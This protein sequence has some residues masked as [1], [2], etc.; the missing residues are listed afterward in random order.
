MSERVD[1]QHGKS[2]RSLLYGLGL[3][4]LFNAFMVGLAIFPVRARSPEAAALLVP[5]EDCADP[6]WQRIQPGITRIGSAIYL[7]RQSGLNFK[8]SSLGPLGTIPIQTSRG[9]LD[10]HLNSGFGGFK[11]DNTIASIC[12][13]DEERPQ[14]SLWL[15][16]VLAALGAPDEVRLRPPNGNTV[17]VLIRYRTRQ[18]EAA[19][20]L[21]LHRAR[22]SPTTPVDMLCFFPWRMFNYDRPEES[23]LILDWRGASSILHYYAGPPYG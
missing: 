13:V 6:C 10:A 12:L 14:G 21:P 1:N 18:I 2:G 5:P 3:L 16:E 22:L 15:G 8:P 17:R 4:L 23:D 20:V 11:A 9:W 19:V 7:L